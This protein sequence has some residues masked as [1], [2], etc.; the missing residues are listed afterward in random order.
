MPDVV[1]D[2]I[3]PVTL[4]LEARNIPVDPN[5]I[6]FLKLTP[7]GQAPMF[8]ESTPLAGTFELSAAA[9]AV[10]FSHGLT[11]VFVEASWLP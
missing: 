5:T 6:V 1:I 10:T 3:Q 9:A 2:E 7:E 4:N 11:R 8:T